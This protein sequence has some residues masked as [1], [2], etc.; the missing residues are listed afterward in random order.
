MS[1]TRI[2]SPFTP[3]LLPAP[4]VTDDGCRTSTD[5]FSPLWLFSDVVQ[6]RRGSS[7]LALFRCFPARSHSLRVSVQVRC[8]FRRGFCFRPFSG[9]L[10]CVFAFLAFHIS[11]V[12]CLWDDTVLLAFPPCFLGFYWGDIVCFRPL[13]CFCVSF[14]HFLFKISD[15]H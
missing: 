14:S 8:P 4:P 12:R 9:Y 3:L 15:K 2:P 5:D 13:P 11:I 7:S 6:I 10:L 1:A